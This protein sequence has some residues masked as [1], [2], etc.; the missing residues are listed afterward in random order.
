MSETVNPYNLE[1]STAVGHTREC[2]VAQSSDC[3][4]ECR[5]SC[6]AGWVPSRGT[7]ICCHIDKVVLHNGCL[8][9]SCTNVVTFYPMMMI[10]VRDK[11]RWDSELWNVVLGDHNNSNVITA[12]R[13]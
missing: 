10:R 3:R 7:G 9:V 2:F 8:F 4:S 13:K 12:I 5:T 11:E 1:I 6:S